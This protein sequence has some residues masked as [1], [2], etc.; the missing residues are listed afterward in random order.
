[1]CLRFPFI[2]GN[3]KSAFKQVNSIMLTQSAAKKYF[4]NEDPMGKVLHI[5]VLG[6]MMVSGVLK[7]IPGNAHFHFDFLI[8]IRKFQGSID[9]KLGMV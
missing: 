8:P 4:G 7:D 9:G 5:D 6:D 2:E 1:M 3:A